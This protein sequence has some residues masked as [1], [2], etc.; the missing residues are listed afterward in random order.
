MGLCVRE[1]DVAGTARPTP[2]CI[3]Q[4]PG[5]VGLA[6]LLRL[7]VFLFI[8]FRSCK[9]YSNVEVDNVWRASRPATPKLGPLDGSGKIHLSS[10][11]AALDER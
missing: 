4:F 1:D 2:L 10:S 6:P 7:S 8:A 3:E 5:P 9:G 11:H